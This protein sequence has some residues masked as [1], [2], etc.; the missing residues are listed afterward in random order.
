MSWFRDFFIQA[1]T[2][3]K[4]SNLKAFIYWQMGRDAFDG[5][6]CRI[7][8]TDSEAATWK[9]EISRNR[10]FWVSHAETSGGTTV[11]GTGGGL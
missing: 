2:I 7:R 11:T 10:G 5:S 4:Y 1:K 6:D 9:A 3:A 8:T